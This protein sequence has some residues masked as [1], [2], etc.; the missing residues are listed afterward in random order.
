[1]TDASQGRPVPVPERRPGRRGSGSS[2]ATAG[3][4]SGRGS[5]SAASLNSRPLQPGLALECNQEGRSGGVKKQPGKR[6]KFSDRSQVTKGLRNL[7]LQCRGQAGGEDAFPDLRVI[8]GP[9]SD[10][11]RCRCSRLE[12]ERGQEP[13]ESS[14]PSPQLPRRRLLHFPLRALGKCKHSPSAYLVRGLAGLEEKRQKVRRLSPPAKLQHNLLEPCTSRAQTAAVAALR[15][16]DPA[17]SR[18]C[19]P[20]SAKPLGGHCLG[21]PARLPDPSHASSALLPGRKRPRE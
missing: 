9:H 5:C 18:P 17:P 14:A 15:P 7:C 10:G 8:W 20:P 13:K 16:L 12:E 19:P 1:M 6:P 21:R 2:A 4:W 11:T 3:C